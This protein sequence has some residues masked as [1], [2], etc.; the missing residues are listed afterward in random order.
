MFYIVGVRGSHIKPNTTVVE[1]LTT[2]V[3]HSIVTFIKLGTGLLCHKPKIFNQLTIDIVSV[4]PKL[5][6]FNFPLLV[7]QYVFVDIFKIRGGNFK[8]TEFSYSPIVN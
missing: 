6:Q 4:Q 1:A 5:W 8:G 2:H 7:L 3:N